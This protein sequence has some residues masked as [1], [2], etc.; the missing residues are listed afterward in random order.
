MF[1]SQ[2]RK[3]CHSD[4]KIFV[5]LRPNQSSTDVFPLPFNP[6]TET[7]KLFRAVSALVSTDAEGI[8]RALA[9]SFF[10]QVI[11]VETGV[12]KPA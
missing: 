4:V 8:L 9:V 12:V 1:V 7:V 6:L 5:R 3:S 2:V 11:R 10:L